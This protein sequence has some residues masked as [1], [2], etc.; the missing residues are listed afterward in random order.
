MEPTGLSEGFE[1]A[2]QEG[3]QLYYREA[4]LSNGVISG[5]V[6]VYDF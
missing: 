4:V 6:Q 3:V 1:A 2:F 5:D